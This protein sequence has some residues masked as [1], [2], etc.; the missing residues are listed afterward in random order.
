MKSVQNPH[1]SNTIDTLYDNFSK[2]IHES[3]AVLPE[4]ISPKWFK[5]ELYL[6][7]KRLKAGYRQQIL[8]FLMKKAFNKFCR[9]HKMISEIDRESFLI[10]KAEWEKRDF[11]KNLKSNKVSRIQLGS[12]ISKVYLKLR[13]KY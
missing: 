9:K 12:H 6:L 5:R 10:I 2:V 3:T 4:G 7:H 1:D 13:A 11:N 8:F